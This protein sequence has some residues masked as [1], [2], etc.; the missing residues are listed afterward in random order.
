MGTGLKPDIRI[1]AVLFDFGQTLADSA[2]GFRSAEK[3][4]QQKIF[5]NL[6][7]TEWEQFL[8]NYRRIRADFNAKSKLSRF[9]I[10]Q[11]VYWY[12]C[13]DCKKELLQK[14]EHEYWCKVKKNTTLFPETRDVLKELSKNYKLA[15]IT[16]TEGQKIETAHRISLFPD[17]EKFFSEAIIAGRASIPP[18]PDPA[19]FKLCL[20]KLDIE[21]AE[22]VYVGDDWDKDIC[23]AQSA[24]LKPVWIKHRFV[25]RNWPQIETN[26]P[27]INSLEELL[28][29]D[30]SKF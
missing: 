29:L 7:L 23:G 28:K 18:K 22:A 1:K 11:E 30:F 20:Q 16:N 14:W 8:Q 6:A 19:P 24:G 3:D 4:A 17:L 26:V 25:Q 21:P 27:V 15:L 12:Y 10:W 2:N 5:K 9:E 13:R